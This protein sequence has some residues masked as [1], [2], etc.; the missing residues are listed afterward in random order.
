MCVFPKQLYKTEQMKYDIDLLKH[1][2]AI[3]RFDY[4]YG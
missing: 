2:T 3:K 1:S 4:D